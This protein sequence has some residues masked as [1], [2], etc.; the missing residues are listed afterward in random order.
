[1][2]RWATLATALVLSAAAAVQSNTAFSQGVNDGWTVLFDGK[3]LDQWD[4]DNTATFKIEDGSVIATDKKDPKATASYLISKKS[5][6]NFIVRA[7]F[8]VSDDANSGLFLRCDPKKIG[9]KT[10]YEYNIFDTRP[11][12]T[13]G[14]ASIVYIAEVNPMPKAGGKWS[15][16]E[17]GA[18]GRHL[19][20]VFD[21]KKTVDV[22]NGLFEEGHIAL[23]FG[24]G[25]VKFRKIEIKPL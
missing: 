14:T 4:S 2:T 21:G 16:M 24:A 15:T 13:Y 25:T 8:W 22:R 11:D 6:K 7:E 18:N 9:A 3:N 12:Q 10:C 17:A 1:M 23:Q 20:V 19:T 5:Y